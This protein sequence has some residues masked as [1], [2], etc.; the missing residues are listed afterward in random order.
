MEPFVGG[1]EEDPS[2]E[3]PKEDGCSTRGGP[4]D[5]EGPF[6]HAAPVPRLVEVVEAPPEQLE[7]LRPL[8]PSAFA[9][10]ARN[11]FLAPELGP[12]LDIIIMLCG[13]PEPFVVVRKEPIY[14]LFTKRLGFTRRKEPMLCY[15][16]FLHFCP[17][18][19]VY[20]YTSFQQHPWTKY[21]RIFTSYFF[22]QHMQKCSH[23]E[24]PML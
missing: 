10:L 22:T 23:A 12:P 9:E 19:H 2:C 24:L 8:R 3:G 16:K 14:Y 4:P 6:S 7:F 21:P 11:I 17:Q 15:D 1:K 20:T 5:V 13:A 18:L